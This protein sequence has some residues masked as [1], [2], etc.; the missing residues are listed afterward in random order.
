[1]CAA[2][3]Y[4]NLAGYDHKLLSI[5]GTRT[6]SAKSHTILLFMVVIFVFVSKQKK[7]VVTNKRQ[8]HV[9]DLQQLMCL[10]A[11]D[12][13]RSP[14]SAETDNFYCVEAPG[15]PWRP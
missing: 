8:T 15:R 11:V 1:M 9:R 6:V 13:I 3:V 4:P 2:S 5:H 14:V 10:C 7:I 12:K